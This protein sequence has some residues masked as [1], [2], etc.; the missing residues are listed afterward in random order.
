MFADHVS[1]NLVLIDMRVTCRHNLRVVAIT[2][3]IVVNKSIICF[4]LSSNLK[5]YLGI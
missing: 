3:V 1:S 2:E 5:A 4:R